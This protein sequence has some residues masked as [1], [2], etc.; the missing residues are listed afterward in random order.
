[1]KH[2]I[3][4]VLSGTLLVDG[5]A[6]A[7]AQFPVKIHSHSDYTRTMPFYEAYSQKVYSIEIDMFY[8]NGS[9]YVCHD[10]EDINPEYTFERMYL[11]PLL[12]LYRG[13][14]GMAWADSDRPIQL[15]A[16]I[17]SKNTEDYLN[18]FSGI[19][20]KYPEVF[21]PKVN[22]DAVRIVIT[23]N[24]PEPKDFK[25]YPE[26]IMFDGN[27]SIDYTEDQFKRVGLYSDK[28]RRNSKWN[29]KGSIVKK[30]KAELIKAIEIAHSKGKPV[31]FWGAPDGI[32]AWNT[33]CMLGIDYI[34]TDKIAP[35]TQFFSNW[36]N[37]TYVIGDN[38]GKVNTNDVNTS[39]ITGTDRLDKTTHDFE[40]FHNDKLKLSEN[41]P[42]YKPEYI[43]DG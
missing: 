33:F 41:I 14:K 16:E 22:P 12:E 43:N 9:F 3:S 20:E 28:F 5:F 19:L 37:K 36:H 32:T 39:T 26:Y 15:M 13:N 8:K 18:A 25:K 40:G 27:F 7:H 42:V 1:M 21:N 6:A 2:I 30:E 10:E 17:K 35:C 24:I 29:G 4:Y 34:N 23:G 11:N 31:R 38:T